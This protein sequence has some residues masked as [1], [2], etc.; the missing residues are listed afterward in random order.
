MQILGSTVKTI[1]R[2]PFII[3]FFGAAALI[4]CIMNSYNPAVAILSGLGKITGGNMFESVISLLQV[5]I[6]PKFIMI[7]V[8]AILGISAAAAV[9]AGLVLSGGLN[10]IDAAVD[11]RPSEKGEF[12]SGLRKFFFR[13][14]GISFKV[15]FLS[16]VFTLFLM[17]AAVP[18]IIATS[19]AMTEKPDY[20]LAAVFIDILTAGVF[21]FGLMF[22]RAYLVFWFPAAY[23]GFSKPYIAG[24]RFA[25]ENFWSIVG[26]FL[27]FDVVFALYLLVKSVIKSSIVLFAYD[28]VFL[29]LFPSMF[30]T[31]VFTYYKVKGHTSS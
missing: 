19:T 27:A 7:V 21:F 31:Y 14:S 20:M 11:G 23:D 10:V 16:S 24:K 30:V 18:A 22:F 28:W 2:R 12:L 4:Y 17:V 9:G 1:A 8:L 15:F 26:R 25:Y 13:V 3:L 6:E 29:T 5:L